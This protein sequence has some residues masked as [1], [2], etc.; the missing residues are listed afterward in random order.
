MKQKCF[1]YDKFLPLA[2]I[3]VVILTPFGEGINEHFIKMI[4]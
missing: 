4:T 2:A 1:H 3:E